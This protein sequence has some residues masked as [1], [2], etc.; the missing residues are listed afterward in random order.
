MQCS[1]ARCSLCSAPLA[2]T[3]PLASPLVPGARLVFGKRILA[4][5]VFVNGIAQTSSGSTVQVQEDEALRQHLAASSMS[6]FIPLDGPA[7]LEW[8]DLSFTL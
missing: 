5:S 7:V 3:P 6:H 2:F 8:C 1:G 4:V